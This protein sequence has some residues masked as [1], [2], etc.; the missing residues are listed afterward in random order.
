ME[1][2]MSS[3]RMGESS[4]SVPHISKIS[5]TLDARPSRQTPLYDFSWGRP[6][7]GRSDKCME[8]TVPCCSACHWAFPS[9]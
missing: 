2:H 3:R 7:K 1:V 9:K 6:L 8:I 5:G 4:L